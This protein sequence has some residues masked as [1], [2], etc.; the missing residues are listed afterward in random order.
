MGRLFGNARDTTLLN[1][2][3]S[4]LLRQAGGRAMGVN[5]PRRAGKSQ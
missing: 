4:A 2:V 5:A 3:F 1:I